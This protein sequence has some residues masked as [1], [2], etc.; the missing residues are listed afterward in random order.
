[1]D[2]LYQ[3]KSVTSNLNC[4]EGEMGK[5]VLDKMENVFEKNVFETMCK[6]ADVP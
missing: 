5:L 1:M 4:G 6:I 2:F 3:V